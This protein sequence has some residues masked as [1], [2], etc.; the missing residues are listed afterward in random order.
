MIPVA[1]E[2]STFQQVRRVA[3][4]ERMADL[5]KRDPPDVFGVVVP[6]E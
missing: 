1:H 6:V 3:Q 4:T 5:M 2:V